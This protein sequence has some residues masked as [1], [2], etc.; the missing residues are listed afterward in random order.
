MKFHM[1]L[2][3]RSSKSYATTI[4]QVACSFLDPNKRYFIKWTYEPKIKKWTIEFTENKGK[5]KAFYTKLWKR[6][7]RSYATTIPLIVLLHIDEEKKYYEVP[8]AERFKRILHDVLSSHPFDSGFFWQKQK[9]N[10]MAFKK[11]DCLV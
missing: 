2:W 4:P 3:R 10:W 7:Q 5:N 1:R 11:S 6:S 9:E 8:E